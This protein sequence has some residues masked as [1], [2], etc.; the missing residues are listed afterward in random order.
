MVQVHTLLLDPAVAHAFDTMRT[1]LQSKTATVERLQSELQG[2]QY[3]S[4]SK[5]GMM[6]VAKCRALQV[7]VVGW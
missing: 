1:A 5:T 2:V 6:L 3:T 4:E 7:S